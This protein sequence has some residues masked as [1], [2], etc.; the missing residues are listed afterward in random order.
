MGSNRFTEHAQNL[1]GEVKRTQGERGKL[2]NEKI[3]KIN[4]V[5]L[6]V[7]VYYVMLYLLL[8]YYIVLYLYYIYYITILNI[9][10]MYS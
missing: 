2:G 1:L 3:V 7:L 6:I 9:I 10:T 5:V 4:Y 8:Y